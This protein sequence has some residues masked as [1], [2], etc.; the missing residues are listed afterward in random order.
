MIA[1]EIFGHSKPK[2]EIYI[3]TIRQ[4]NLTLEDVENVLFIGDNPYTDIIGAQSIGLKTVWISMGR[5]YPENL[6]PPDYMVKN[7]RELEI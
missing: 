7:F 1:S 6:K 2:K 3:E 5:K 4:L